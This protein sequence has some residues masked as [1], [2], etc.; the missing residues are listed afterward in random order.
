MIVDQ[1]NVHGLAVLEAEHHAPVARNADSPLARAVAL[2]GVQP[3]ARRVGIARMR[4]LVQP[5][6]DAP[7][8]WRE[9]CRKPRGIV[10]L[11]QRPQCLVPG[12]HDSL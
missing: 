12:P 1:V 7:E 9:T 5:E 2:Q 3:E 10:A 8:P 11:V 6:Q 4:C